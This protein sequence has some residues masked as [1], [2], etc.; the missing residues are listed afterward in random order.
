MKKRSTWRRITEGG[1]LDQ[2]TTVTQR[3]VAGK[4]ELKAV[5]DVVAQV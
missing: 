3:M 4:S 5:Y 1:W 2:M